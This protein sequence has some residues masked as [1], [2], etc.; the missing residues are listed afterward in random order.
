MGE[1]LRYSVRQRELTKDK[2]EQKRTRRDK[3]GQRGT[4]TISW[5]GSIRIRY[6]RLSCPEG[7]SLS[8]T[9]KGER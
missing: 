8:K 9:R 2:A 5:R 6:G 4:T 7:Q 1:I 3:A